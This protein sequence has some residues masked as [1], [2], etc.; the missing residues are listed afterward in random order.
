MIS[1]CCNSSTST[2][3]PLLGTLFNTISHFSNYLAYL[4]N[5]PQQSRQ[6]HQ[7]GRLS[8]RFLS[9][10]I[11]LGWIALLVSGPSIVPA[12]NNPNWKDAS[13]NPTTNLTAN[14]PTFSTHSQLKLL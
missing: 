3:V 11:Q 12:D 5:T 9:S 2:L 14:R 1:S 13:T 6:I 10:T 7:R 8:P 4:P